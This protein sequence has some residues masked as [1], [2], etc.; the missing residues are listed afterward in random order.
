[1][2][3]PSLLH[4]RLE[5][6]DNLSRLPVKYSELLQKDADVDAGTDNEEEVCNTEMSDSGGDES[7][8]KH[9]DEKKSLW[10]F[11]PSLLRFKAF[12]FFFCGSIGALFP[13]LAIYFKQLG[14]S[15]NQIGIISG[16][17]PIA[18]F[19]GCVVIGSLADRFRM[20]RVCLMISVVCSLS[21]LT[22]IGFIPPAH[23]VENKC[24]PELQ[25]NVSSAS[26]ELSAA[27]LAR[28]KLANS[29]A[30]NLINNT[31]HSSGESSSKSLTEEFPKLLEDR[32]W[33]FNTKELSQI[34]I[35]ILVLEVSSDA[36][37]SPV[38]TLIET[39][40][41]A[42]LGSDNLS[43]YGR[44]RAWSSLG[45]GIMSIVSGSIVSTTHEPREICGSTVVF[46]DYRIAF[47]L[48]AVC[49]GLCFFI[50]LCFKFKSTEETEESQP[51]EKPNP[52]KVF[53]FFLT[54]HYGAWLFC[55]LF[56]GVCNGV[57]WGFLNWHLENIGGTQ[58]MIG[59][60]TS[61]SF[62]AELLMFFVIHL[63]IKR[64][65]HA[66]LIYLGLLSYVIR[67]SVFA[68]ITNP[69]Y[70][71][72]TEILQ[73]FSFAGIWVVLVD[74]LCGSVPAAYLATVQGVMHGVY[75][76]MGNGSGH[77]IAG[78]LIENFG[79]QVTFWAFAVV[80][81]CLLL[82]FFLSQ[83]FSKRGEVFSAY[84]TLKE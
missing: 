75:F 7:S 13:Y 66:N 74:Y 79:A 42:E 23:V 82:L 16:L 5:K 63:L 15:P 25:P 68:A 19:F 36:V 52:F 29:N 40:C 18:G 71:L 8:K 4:K 78:V 47:I 12:Y 84:N 11:E 35:L 22:S 56:M 24:P 67:F 50:A 33:M 6:N 46:S 61:V 34:F 3:V 27:P 60:A 1:M 38:G 44:Q 73:G 37:M 41:L 70:V 76:G 9:A 45:L 62:G 31:D 32:G 51:T 10:K 54:L 2:D 55:M 30:T 28:S 58:F 72:P 83:K 26:S 77:M 81:G 80:S 65:G 43:K 69:W 39:G 21:L 59:T 49:Q 53:K 57:I 20:R 14:F 48:F 64:M 17:R